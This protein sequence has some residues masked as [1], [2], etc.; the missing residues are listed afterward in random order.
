MSAA[1]PAH[2]GRDSSQWAAILELPTS[3]ARP[4]RRKQR[5]ERTTV[6]PQP[7]RELNPHEKLAASL[8]HLFAK[9]GRSLTDEETVQDFLIALAAFRNLLE[10]ARVQGMLTEDTHRDLD[11]MLEGMA[12]APGLL[13]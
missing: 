11:G 12:A 7:G 5:R 3:A 10:G 8:E 4:L 1:E 13:A 9:H 2:P 6:P